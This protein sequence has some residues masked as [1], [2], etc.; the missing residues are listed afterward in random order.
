MTAGCNIWVCLA[1]NGPNW[2]LRTNGALATTFVE[3]SAKFCT[4]KLAGKV[5][6]AR[7]GVFVSSIWKQ[8]SFIMRY[9]SEGAL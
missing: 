5:N 7:D 4:S 1:I 9:R 8:N 2:T 3:L 6:L